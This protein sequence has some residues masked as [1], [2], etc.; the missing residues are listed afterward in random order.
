MQIYTATRT[1]VDGDSTFEY[2]HSGYTIYNPDGSF[3]K[4]VRNHAG[5]MDPV[6]SVVAIPAG[7]YLIDAQAEEYG[8]VKFTVEVK[9]GRLNVVHLEKDPKHPA[10]QH[11]EA[12]V[13]RLPN[14]KA[15]G[16]RE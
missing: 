6:P 3:F 11:E 2:P 15:V 4:Y 16:W 12:Q 7:Q 1:R 13:I 5:R 14:G 9:P 10:A 8:G